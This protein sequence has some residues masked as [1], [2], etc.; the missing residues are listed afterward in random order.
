MYYMTSSCMTHSYLKINVFS[1]L[2]WPLF[3]QGADNFGRMPAFFYIDKLCLD[4]NL[5]LFVGGIAGLCLSRRAGM[6]QTTAK[7]DADS[8]LVNVWN[9]L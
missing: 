2:I 1:P 4:N 9:Q 8:A 3:W 5:V 6:T 7:R